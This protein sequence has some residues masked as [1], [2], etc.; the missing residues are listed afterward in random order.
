[1]ELKLYGWI[2]IIYLIISIGL[3]VAGLWCAKKFAKTEKQQAIVLKCIA[4][5]LFV[6]IAINRLSQVYRYGL[7]RPEQII[8]D[9]FCGMSSL[10][11]SLSVLFGKK[12]NYVYHFVWFLALIGGVITILYP[13]FIDQGPSF[14]YLPT[15]SG[16][17]HHSAAIAMVAAL[18]LFK[19]ITITYKKWYCVI[20]GFTA[21]LTVGAFLMSVFGFSDAYHIVEPMIDG[22]PLTVWVVAPIYLTGHALIFLIVE[23]IRK[24]KAKT[25]SKS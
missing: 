9:S 24:K 14:F 15:I 10:V 16:M 4:G 20:L 5:F 6:W 19:Q 7:Y 2:H 18:L 8:P 11:L 13:T 22:T 25:I 23:L 17:I 21:Y 1:M 12:D 3:T